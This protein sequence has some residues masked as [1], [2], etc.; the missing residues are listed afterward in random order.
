MTT[1]PGNEL[2]TLTRALLDCIHAADW[3]TYKRLCDP[4]LTCFEP[5]AKSHQVEGLEFHRYYF[6][7]GAGKSSST[8]AS[9]T[10]RPLGESAA[11]VSYT[12]LVQSLDGNGRPV[13]RTFEETRVWQ[14][15][16]GAWKHVHFH[17]SANAP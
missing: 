17:R 7:L 6:N 8:I 5:E 9:P 2:L 13:T 3:E 10:V 15:I 12:R 4:T 11:V 16:Q 14:K 1:P